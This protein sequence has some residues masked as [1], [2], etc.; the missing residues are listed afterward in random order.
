MRQYPF[1]SPRD[2]S[3]EL[4]PARV[5]FI[6]QVFPELLGQGNRWGG[7][8]D[9]GRGPRETLRWVHDRLFV[10]GWQIAAV[11]AELI[12]ARKGVRVIAV[13]SGKGGVGKTTFSVNLAVA[14][15]LQ[16]QRVLLFDADFGMANVHVFAGVNPKSTILDVVDG[17]A[18][19][20]DVVMAGPGGI[21]VI[22]GVSGVARLANLDP[23]ILEALGREL[24]EIATDFDLLVIDTGAGVSPIVTHFLGLAQEAVVV[25]TPNLAATL[26]AYGIIKVAHESGLKARTQVLVNQARDFDEAT[27]VLA[28]IAG[29]ASSFLQTSPGHLGFLERDVAFEEA[30]QQRCPLI[31]AQPSNLNALRIAAI[32]TQLTAAREAPI[33]R[34]WERDLSLSAEN[35]QPISST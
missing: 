10:E 23:C 8:A 20:A 18:D 12:R 34:P 1:P 3:A 21:K 22:C 13:T 9:L 33:P 35:R 16:G 30:N 5:Q 24:M 32:A 11:R 15:A 25:T 19:L 31:L 28:R 6:Q 7:K 14:C 4:Q 27:A 17:R 26:D 29:C 2:S